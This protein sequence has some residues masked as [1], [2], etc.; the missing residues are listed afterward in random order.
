[1][2]WYIQPTAQTKQKENT[3]E[4]AQL[5]DVKNATCTIW[6]NGMGWCL[7]PVLAIH[8]EGGSTVA[9]AVQSL[10]GDFDYITWPSIAGHRDD[11]LAICGYGDYPPASSRLRD[12][13]ADWLMIADLSPLDDNDD[14]DGHRALAE[15]LHD[16]I[17]AAQEQIVK[18][19][20][21]S[22]FPPETVIL[23]WTRLTDRMPCPNE[24]GLVLIYT[25]GYDF[26][27]KNIFCVEADTL[28][29]CFYANQD[30]QPD[31]C[32]HAT[33]WAA[34]PSCATS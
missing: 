2:G 28:N 15:S 23:Q 5:K 29:E 19:K 34:I 25:E 9:I 3:M 16:A 7:G 24:H 20:S 13:I 12:C 4:I 31:M 33:H 32:R 21:I 26:N 8:G 11:W 17:K 10:H 22:S 6:R 18:E 30:D 1:M 14:E 27:G